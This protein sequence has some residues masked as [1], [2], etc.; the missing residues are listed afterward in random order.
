MNKKK[1]FSLLLTASLLFSSTS[2]VFAADFKISQP[3]P[4]I[5]TTL[6][7]SSNSE[8]RNVKISKEQ[9]KKIAKEKLKK[10]FDITIS[11]QDFK[12]NINLNSYTINKDNKNYIWHMNWYSNSHNSSKNISLTLDANT[13]DLISM[14]NYNYNENNSSIPKLSIEDAKEI[15]NKFIK[16][17]NPS[18]YKLCELSK[19]KWFSNRGT[20]SDY[21][22]NYVRNIYGAKYYSNY[23]TVTIDGVTGKIK[24][25]NFNWDK[26]LK[27]P[28]MPKINLREIAESNFKKEMNMELK[29]KL[30]QNKYEYQNKDNTKNVKLVY[31]PSIEK[32]YSIDANTG[33]FLTYDSDKNVNTQT[34]KL[35]ETE[36][37]NLYKNYKKLSNYTKPLEKEEASK[38]M[39]N[40]VKKFYG[41]GYTIENL[42]YSENDNSYKSTEKKT[43][44][45]SF[46]KKIEVTNPKTNK[47]VSRTLGGNITLNALNGQILRIS[48][49]LSSYYDYDKNFTP[50]F[51]WNEGYYKAVDL[52]GEHYGDKIKNLEL[53]LTHTETI[54]KENDQKK[55]ERYYRYY[56]T[57]KVNNLLYD[58]DNIYIEFDTKTGQL[59]SMRCSWDDDISF[60]NPN[61]S[62]SIANAKD[63]FFKKYKPELRFIMKNTSN[64]NKNPKMELKLVYVLDSPNV[65]IDAF[66]TNILNRYDGEEIK[67]DISHFLNEIKES[68]YEKEITIL[69]YSG[70]VDTK[71]FTLKKEIKNMDLIKTLVDALGYTPYIV[72]R[73]ET[74]NKSSALENSK[75]DSADTNESALTNED[76]LKMAKYYGFIDGDIKNFNF[77]KKVSREEMCK[78]LIK[79][80]NYE[81]IAEC[82]DTFALNFEDGNK[83]SKENYGYVSLAKGLKLIE[84]NNNKLNPKQTATMEDLAIG[85]FRALENKES[86]RF[87]PYPLYR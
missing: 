54:Y 35:N 23:I 83:V 58:N 43:W 59:V 7:A 11:E 12:C 32:G 27:V 47:K 73:V 17:I 6:T 74:Y 29:Y 52:L 62:I 14:N 66:N 10:Y 45:A 78:A 65:Y 70:L 67:F 37:Q 30:L 61:N 5:T 49:Y 39:T 42:S 16:N 50:K 9:A 20:Y 77:E 76:Y 87:Y 31:E 25:Y 63:S 72:D 4:A 38:L 2:Y 1:I 68:K 64:D 60:K 8:E 28:P 41:N 55:P 3:E 85:L 79:F 51:T 36:I 19:D 81:K 34:A 86:S 15:S 69:A 84:L 53:N 21:S 75:S 80:L 48:N 71:D 82:K 56:F 33:K 18:E 13:G 22:F 40:F 24:S 57:R 44:R 46:T 26:N